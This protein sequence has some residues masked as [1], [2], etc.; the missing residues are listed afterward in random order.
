M[1]HCMLRGCP[2]PLI[3]MTST[4][5]LQWAYTPLETP[6]KGGAMVSPEITDLEPGDERAERSYQ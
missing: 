1:L 5:V 2:R 6:H 3:V 4:A